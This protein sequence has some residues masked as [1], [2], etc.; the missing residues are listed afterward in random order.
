MQKN[1]KEVRETCVKINLRR[2]VPMKYKDQIL[3][4]KKVWMR[5]SDMK[6]TSLAAEDANVRKTGKEDELMRK[7]FSFIVVGIVSDG[8][9]KEDAD[10]LEKFNE[11]EIQDKKAAKDAELE[12][13]ENVCPVSPV[14]SDNDTVLPFRPECFAARNFSP[15]DFK[16]L[17]LVYQEYNNILEEDVQDFAQFPEI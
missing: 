5:E 11:E 16:R 8:Y 6:D 4:F 14:F 13:T 12:Y 7:I 15:G 17:I 2:G 10:A 1:A 3:F 9:T